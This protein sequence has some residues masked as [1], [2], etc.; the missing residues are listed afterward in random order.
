KHALGLS[1]VRAVA[2]AHG[3]DVEA[4]AR[5]QGGLSVTVRLP[6]SQKWPTIPAGT[7]LHGTNSA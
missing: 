7:P 1:I 2:R 5:P 4:T 3:G 6:T